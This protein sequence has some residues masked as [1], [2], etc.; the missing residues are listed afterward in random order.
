MFYHSRKYRTR[1]SWPTASKYHSRVFCC[2]SASRP[3]AEIHTKIAK[4]QAELQAKIY[5]K[6]VICYSMLGLLH[7][8]LFDFVCTECHPIGRASW[9]WQRFS[10]V[11]SHLSS[12]LLSMPF[13]L[14]FWRL[15]NI[16]KTLWNLRVMLYVVML[17]VDGEREGERGRERPWTCVA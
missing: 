3:R 10:S 16:A 13:E 12:L 15:K 14:G 11:L 1:P 7:C 17:R 8:N 6:G 2:I 9:Q 4:I 5:G